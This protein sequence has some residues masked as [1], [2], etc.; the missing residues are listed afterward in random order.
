QLRAHLGLEQKPVR[1]Y[2]MVQQLAVVDDD[3]LD[4][5]NVDTVELGRGFLLEQD[6]W[7]DWILPDG[8]P[9]QIPHYVQ[10]EKRDNHWVVFTEDGREL[11]VQRHGWL[12]F[13]QTYY[14]L[15]KRPMKGDDF[16]DLEDVVNQTLWTGIPSPGSHLPLSQ[17]GLAEMRNKAKAFR[18]S[19][20]RAVVGLFGGNMFEIPQWLYGMD[21]YFAS[22]KLFPEDV[23]R[24]SEKLCAL[25]LKNLERWLGAVGEFIDVIVFGDDLGG[26]NGLLISPEMYRQFIKPFQK[27]LWNRAKALADVKV[28]LHCCGD[29][30]SI[31]SDLIDA[32]LDAINPVQISC[33]GMD[34]SRLKSL[35]GEKLTFWGGGC[36]TRFML[37]S[38][39]KEDIQKHV[40]EQVE[41]F[42]V[43]GGFIFQQVHNVMAD[44]PIENVI[45]MF[46]AVNSSG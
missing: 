7:K 18:N 3:V 16:S 34:S 32:G 42:G 24:F 23:L 8:S 22:L 29:V 25:H 39:T 20:Q 15:R 30:S 9:C 10:L 46:E 36:D 45:A 26:Q 31:M 38:S 44:V 1:V 6:D 41:K 27:Q 14:P 5:F 33:P 13:E 2:D 12:Y 35:F 21:Q 17:A 28:M 4:R 43:D 11:G 40:K 37:P 19:T